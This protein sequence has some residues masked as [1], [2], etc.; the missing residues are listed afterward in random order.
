MLEDATA[1]N[2]KQDQAVMDTTTAMQRHTSVCMYRANI[3]YVGACVPGPAA[4][5]AG[6]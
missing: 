4:S 3:I 5:C 6:V 2:V 1:A